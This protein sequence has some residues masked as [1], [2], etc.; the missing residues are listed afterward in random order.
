M[1]WL[2]HASA[3]VSTVEAAVSFPLIVLVL[4]LT[5]EAAMYLHARSVVVWAARE[6]AHAGALEHASMDE[7]I[8]DGRQRTESLLVAGLGGY[9][10]D[11][12]AIDVEDDGGNILVEVRGAYSFAVLGPG[13]SARLALP[14]DARARASY[15]VFRPQGR[16]GF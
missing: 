13:G 9:A 16:G 7:A 11:V 8:A 3:G 15:E 10:R 6:G 2:R 14:L 1:G 12:E 4:V 5:V